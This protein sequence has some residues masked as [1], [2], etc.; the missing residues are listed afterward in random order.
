MLG[1]HSWVS[2][3]TVTGPGSLIGAYTVNQATTVPADS[4]WFGSPAIELPKR[5]RHE[6]SDVAY[7]PSCCMKLG[8]GLSEVIESIIDALLFSAL[9]FFYYGVCSFCILL[10]FQ[11]AYWLPLMMAVPIGYW[12]LALILH[13]LGHWLLVCGAGK[14]R[15]LPLWGWQLNLIMMF[16]R[17]EDILI[18]D[19]VSHCYIYLIPLHLCVL[20]NV[21]VGCAVFWDPLCR[22]N[23]QVDR[24]KSR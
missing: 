4:T 14:S 24:R 23:L 2:P 16:K 3:G 1:N 15:F 20:L 18:R 17:L 13:Q 5:F 22:H 8:R 21:D 12:I 11:P 10:Y 7:Q 9:H 19:L 6:A